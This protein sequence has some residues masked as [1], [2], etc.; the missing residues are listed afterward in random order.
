MDCGASYAPRRRH[1]EMEAFLASVLAAY[2]DRGESE[3]SRSKLG[4]ALTARY[5][6]MSD[7]KA[8]LGHTPNPERISGHSAGAL[9]GVGGL[10]CLAEVTIGIDHN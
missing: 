6:T 10:A 7:A 1:P 4:T 8:S 9:R 3:L 5:G 2:I